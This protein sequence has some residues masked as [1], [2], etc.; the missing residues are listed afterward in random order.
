MTFKRI[1]KMKNILIL[2]VVVLSLN[3]CKMIM[4]KIYGIKNPDV[5][6][7]KSIIKKAMKYGIDTSTI[8][9][10]NSIDFLNV[11]NGHSIPDAGIYDKNGKYIEYRQTDT[12]CNAGLF[13]F[14]SAL[15]LKEK[16]NQPDRANLNT[17]LNKCRDLKG[18]KLTNTEDADFYLLI[19]WTVWTGKLNKNHVKIWQ[20]LAY[21]NK[22]C[23]VKVIM[24]NLDIQEYWEKYEREKI[25][26]AIS[27]RKLK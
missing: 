3:S 21:K 15:N 16:Y 12:S 20:D 8:V 24:V 19:Y 18:N 11:L 10:V 27:N 13:D 14:I 4:M 26:K 25:I 1:L 6:D 17:E 5:E 9:T 22:N 23:K 7:D 2:I